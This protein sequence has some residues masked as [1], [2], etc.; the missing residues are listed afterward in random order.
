MI[1][2]GTRAPD[3]KLDSQFD[4]EFSMS[5]FKGEKNVM[6]AFYPFDWSSTWSREIPKIESMIYRFKEA[7]T[8][9]LGVSIDSKHSHKKWAESLGGVSFPLLQDFHPKGSVATSYGTYLENKG[10][11]A[12][13]TVIVDKQGVIR[14]SVMADGERTITEL[15]AECQKVNFNN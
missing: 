3:F 15:L 11:A 4:T 5:E 9:V 14:Y 12:R 7:D 13:S 1:A 6:L 8:Q 10:F 2:V